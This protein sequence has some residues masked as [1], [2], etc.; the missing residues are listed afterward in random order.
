[1]AKRKH[2]IE[3][4]VRARDEASRKFNRIGR[5]GRDM[6]RMIKRALVGV[7]AYLGA[8]Q[9]VTFFRSA[10][11]NYIRQENAVR[12]LADALGLLGA[13]ASE[14]LGGL[15]EFAKEIQNLTIYG[16]EAVIEAMA[17]GAAVGKLSGERLKQAT[18]A[19]IGLS[20][21]FKVDLATAMRLVAR[22]AV[23]D[24][25]TLTRYGIKLGDAKT[26]GE[27]FNKVLKIGAENFALAE[28]QAKTTGGQIEQLKNIWGDLKEELAVGVVPVLR[29]T[30]A[31]LKTLTM[32]SFK[33]AAAIL[34]WTAA[35]GTAIYLTPKILGAVKAISKAIKGLTTAQVIL[36]ALSGPAGWAAIGTG[37]VVMGVTLGTLDVAF[38]KLFKNIE[39]GQKEFDKAFGQAGIG[40]RQAIGAGGGSVGRMLAGVTEQL[41]RLD[42]AAAKDPLRKLAKDVVALKK[43]IRDF[44]K[45]EGQLL[46]EGLEK[47][48]VHITYRWDIEAL[49]ERKKALE[50]NRKMTEALA[51]TTARLKKELLTLRWGPE[52]VELWGLA[53]MGAGRDRLRAV[54]GLLA[55][56]RAARQTAAGT[57]GTRGALSISASPYAAMRLAPGERVNT[58]EQQT[59][60][61]TSE[62]NRHLRAFL[63]YQKRT[64]EALERIQRSRAGPGLI[65][66]N[67]G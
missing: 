12:N 55:Q 58:Y 28:G 42:K 53:R 43:E 61:N 37:L 40:G 9:M 63:N 60:R 6:G 13:G 67:L 18:K 4:V 45:A 51:E 36:Q 1:M 57:A 17:L 41:G 10:V 5:S 33:S 48:G 23:G 16:D 14:G 52:A 21:A 19:A 65:V 34:K 54:A 64:T 24:T 56:I 46:L 47:A 3:A 15:R 39:K 30:V 20:A 31:W 32:D 2:T 29:Q 44:G 7:G 26:A 50:A 62:M 35:I 38:D 22:A 66:A 11:D 49:L 25:T 8:R 27:K 59:A